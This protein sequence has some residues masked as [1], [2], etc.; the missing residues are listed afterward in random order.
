MST[1]KLWEETG[2]QRQVDFRVLTVNTTHLDGVCDLS[3]YLRSMVPGLY[4]IKVARWSSVK[5]RKEYYICTV[6]SNSYNTVTIGEKQFN[7]VLEVLELRL[8]REIE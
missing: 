3:D 6:K 2:A 8:H 7:D 5:Y 1:V 4:F